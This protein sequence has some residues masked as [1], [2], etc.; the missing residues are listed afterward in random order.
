M[1][2]KVAHGV[3]WR[4]HGGVA[5]SDHQTFISHIL[6][7]VV[8]L[9]AKPALTPTAL[10][11]GLKSFMTFQPS[12][13]EKID[14][15][16]LRL[17]VLESAASEMVLCDSPHMIKEIRWY[18]GRNQN[19]KFYTSYGDAMYFEALALV[20]SQQ[21][22]SGFLRDLNVSE[23]YGEGRTHTRSKTFSYRIP[24]PAHPF[25][26]MKAML[27]NNKE[28]MK[29]EIDFRDGVVVSGS[30]TPSL[31]GFYLEILQHKLSAEA[32]DEHRKWFK[33]PKVN[34]ILEP[35]W[36][37]KTSQTLTASTET[38]FELDGFDGKFAFLVFGIRANSYAAS[39]NGLIKF[40]D[41]GSEA[42]WD[43][44]DTSNKSIHGKATRL[45]LQRNHLNS[46]H[47]HAE[48]FLSNRNLYLIPFVNDIKLA[49][50]GVLDGNFRFNKTKLSLAITP[51]AAGTS[52]V[53]TINCNNPANDGGYYKLMF[54][55][56]MTN[57]LAYNADAAAIKAALEGLQ[58][59][60]DYPG[61]PLT[62]TASGALTTDI[63]LT[64]PATVD[65]P[66]EAKDLVQVVNESLNDG[67]V[68]EYTSSSVT[69]AG[70]KGW[71]TG[72]S[73]TIDIYGWKF[74]D[75]VFMESAIACQ[76]S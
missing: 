34:R 75:L 29:I 47:I 15:M 54:R 12:E 56:E 68:A 58:T 16:Y 21:Q 17:D 69:T 37:T 30:G 73:Y 38:R 43:I 46:H 40:L 36:I 13:I 44:L 59:F 72:S 4:N 63:T 3:N 64:F 11:T 76:D 26:V 39:S 14:A 1:S 20:N 23:A 66:Q 50:H 27:M 42:T 65:P 7:S 2:L 25:S 62:V 53:Q 67:G 22:T 57:S 74:R 33:M 6:P 24:L 52:C 55:G 51:S 41:L 60:K 31:S 48:K 9:E 32:H 49:F 28:E 70:K 10:V 19:S 45:S 5:M 18:A 61:G 71:T 8:E 35:Q